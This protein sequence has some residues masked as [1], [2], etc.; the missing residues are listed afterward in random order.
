MHCS[1]FKS[2]SERLFWLLPDASTGMVAACAFSASGPLC[3]RT[4]KIPV[5]YDAGSA[6]HGHALGIARKVRELNALSIKNGADIDKH[7]AQTEHRACLEECAATELSPET[8]SK[9][10]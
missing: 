4:H 3:S 8:S 5:S 9:N 2:G 6:S 1:N 10:G 7:R